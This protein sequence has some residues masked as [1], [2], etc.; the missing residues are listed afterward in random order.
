MSIRVWGLWWELSIFTYR[1]GIG[2]GIHTENSYH[3]WC[4]GVGGKEHIES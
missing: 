2:L 3:E 1:W 4:L